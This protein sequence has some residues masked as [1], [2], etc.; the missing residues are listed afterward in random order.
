MRGPG[1]VRVSGKG[2]AVRLAMS[3]GLGAI[4][5]A[6]RPAAPRRTPAV[7]VVE[8]RGAVDDSPAEPGATTADLALALRASLFATSRT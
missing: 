4:L 2:S 7:T 5:G 3:A 1:K 6:A 8:R